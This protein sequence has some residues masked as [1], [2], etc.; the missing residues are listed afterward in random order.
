VYEP[1]DRRPLVLLLPD[2]VRLETGAKLVVFNDL[3]RIRQDDPEPTGMDVSTGA[4]DPDTA[5]D[6]YSSNLRA[7]GPP[8]DDADRWRAA[9][10]DLPVSGPEASMDVN[11]RGARADLGSVSVWLQANYDPIVDS[12][13]IKW[14]LSWVP[15]PTVG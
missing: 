6:R 1:T 11:S 3:R 2:D 13:I 14:G 10:E 8:T 15:E 9:V 7:L 5:Y 4:L 12:A